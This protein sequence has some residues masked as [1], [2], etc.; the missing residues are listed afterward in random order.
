RS[1]RAAP[2]ETDSQRK[3]SSSSPRETTDRSAASSSTIMATGFSMGPVSPAR[4][5]RG[6]RSGVL[7]GT[8]ASIL[9]PKEPLGL[10]E[11]RRVD[12]SPVGDPSGASA[13]A[14]ADA[15]GGPA[16]GASAPS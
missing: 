15:R 11:R 4:G 3:P 16:A 1:R 13:D 5:G 7:Q 9:M 14:P 8:G 2:V 6:E 12:A 10:R